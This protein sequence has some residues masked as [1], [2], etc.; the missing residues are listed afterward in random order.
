MMA[1]V[2]PFSLAAG[3]LL[4]FLPVKVATADDWRIVKLA[5]DLETAEGPVWD[6]SGT[7]YFTEIFAQLVHAYSVETG[8]FQVIRRDSGG[9]NGMA[10][11]LDGRLLMCEMAGRRV[12]RMPIGGE[13]EILWK[14][15]GQGKGGPNDIVVS[16]SGR[17]YF[18]MPRHRCVYRIDH[19]G[20]VTVAIPEV[21][22]LN[23]VMLSRD[24]ETLYVTRYREREVLAYR[25]NGAT[26]DADEGRVFARIET[27]GTEHGADG[28]TVDEDE[29]LYVACL[30][31]VWIFDRS[32]REVGRIRLPG[33]NVTN[34]AF[35]GESG[36]ILFVTTQ[37]GLFSARRVVE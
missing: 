17:I 37:R 7:L 2:A 3:L 4:I 30:G 26:G 25:V 36:E 10:L 20:S 11:D 29:R 6:T 35:G 24:E 28:M 5:Y 13:V 15:T 8:E 12:S 27:A 16:S 21:A 31:G 18:T 14:T 9:A 32:G 22:G 33:E 34:C 23:G 1:R 19:D